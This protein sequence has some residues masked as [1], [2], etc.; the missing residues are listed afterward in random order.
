D[1]WLYP[2]FC[3]RK[4][5]RRIAS[6]PHGAGGVYPGICRNLTAEEQAEKAKVKDPSFR[7][8][9][10]DRSI[11]F[12]DLVMGR[13]S[14]PPG[15]GGDFVVKRADGIMSY[16]LAVVVDDAEMEM[17]DVLRGADLLDSTPRQILLYEALGY[18]VPEFGHMPLFYGP[19]G[20]RLSKRH[21]TAITLAAM[22]E[23]GTKPEEVVGYLAYWTGLIHSPEP[24]KAS[25][26]IADFDLKKISRDPVVIEGSLLEK[27]S[28]T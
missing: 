24:L 5:L 23:S 2:C 26:L 10:P 7:F 4:E 14:F 19:D 8:I 1:G 13:R 9:V 27:L 20:N 11:V 18:P 28:R 17:T 6:A 21:G 25:D 12:D 15:Y 16:Q 3:S 22:R